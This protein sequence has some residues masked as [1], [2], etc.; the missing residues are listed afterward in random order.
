MVIFSGRLF[1][2]VVSMIPSFEHTIFENFISVIDSGYIT[3][4]EI[5]KHWG[6]FKI[7]EA[8]WGCGFDSMGSFKI[9]EAFWG[10]GFD[11][12]VSISGSEHFF[13]FLSD[14]HEELGWEWVKFLFMLFVSKGSSSWDFSS[15]W[16]FFIS[17][18]K[19][20]EKV[21][22]NSC[23][24]LYFLFLEIPSSIILKLT[25]YK[26]IIAFPNLN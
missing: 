15:C 20:L 8:F 12:W 23:L 1:S 5:P 22:K 19:I 11:S 9:N 10:S 25:Y 6:S 24:L 2:D 17:S 4:E 14:L 3:S 18:T 7:N 21:L 26:K 16:E 13:G